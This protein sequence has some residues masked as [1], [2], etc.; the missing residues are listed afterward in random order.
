MN[1]S[2]DRFDLDQQDRDGIEAFEEYV[3]YNSELCSHC[4]ARVRDVGPEYSNILRRTSG[5]ELDVP[6]LEMTTNEWYERTD[7]GSQ[8]YCPWDNTKRFGTCF[9]E[10]CGRDT[11]PNHHQLSWEKMKEFA[12]N[13]YAYIRDHTPLTL[14]KRRFCTELSKLKVSRR[15]T[16][17][18]ESQIFAV[19]FARGLQTAPM[20]A[21]ADGKTAPLTE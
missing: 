16:Q 19:A 11:Q 9:C 20:A 7:I 18:K 21:D 14:S 13:L 8:E 15:D 10:N 3:W 4:F 2:T 17:G 1:V 5:T 12:V 6:D